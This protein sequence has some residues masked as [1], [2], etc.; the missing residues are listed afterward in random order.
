M[1]VPMYWPG[2]TSPLNRQ[3]DKYVFRRRTNAKP[4]KMQNKRVAFK[5][6]VTR[7]I[8]LCAYSE[9]I[10]VV[11]GALKMQIVNTIAIRYRFR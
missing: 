5:V 6:S 9:Y 10:V 3:I 8:E 7:R 4:A 1:C 11:P 2:R